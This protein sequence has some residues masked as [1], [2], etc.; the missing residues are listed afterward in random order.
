MTWSDFVEK[1]ALERDTLHRATPLIPASS[2]GESRGILDVAA[3]RIEAFVG[4]QDAS[5]TP[6]KCVV[7]LGIRPLLFGTAWKVIDIF[8]EEVFTV[9]GEEPDQGRGFTIKKKRRLARNGIEP[10]DFLPKDVWKAIGHT[11]DQTAEYRDSLVH[12][13]AYTDDSGA[14]IGHERGGAE[15]QPVSTDEQDA[16]VHVALRLVEAAERQESEARTDGD[17]RARLDDLKG[18][19]KQEILGGVT[20]KRVPELIV[21]LPAGQGG[22][23]V[24]DVPYVRRRSPWSAERYCDL[25]VQF[26]DRPGVNLRGRLEDAPDQ[27]V[28]IDPDQ[29]PEWLS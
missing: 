28:S 29:P 13:K 3:D 23:Y 26:H 8:L 22:G 1:I 19:H 17:L 11:Y 15:L 2:T 14:L 9:A 6:E 7:L 10:P 12:R 18:I 20:L 21:L 25:V 4:A 27:Q 5:L 24:F 16:F